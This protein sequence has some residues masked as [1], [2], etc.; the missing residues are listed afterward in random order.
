MIVAFGRFARF[1]GPRSQC[2]HDAGQHNPGAR[3]LHIPDLGK[4]AGMATV[5]HFDDYPRYGGSNLWT[6]QL[7]SEVRTR[8]RAELPSRYA[9][10]S[11][12]SVY[13]FI[14][15]MAFR[16]VPA[17]GVVPRGTSSSLTSSRLQVV[18][19]DL[20]RT[21]ERRVQVRQSV[22]AVIALAMFGVPAAAEPPSAAAVTAADISAAIGR[23]SPRFTDDE[24][25]RVLEAGP[26]RLGAFVVGRPKKT[27]PARIGADG[28]VE[29]TE[30]L[31]LDEISAVLQ[32]LSG[33][34]EFVV[35]GRLVHSARMTSDDPDA[36]VI[37]PGSRGKAIIGGLRRRNRAGR[38]RDHPG[39][40]GSR[41]C[42]HR[43][44]CDLP[45]DPRRLGPLPTPEVSVPIRLTSS[46]VEVVASSFEV[47]GPLPALHR[48]TS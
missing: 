22:T 41:L 8:I 16:V 9:H 38:H 20:F 2:S 17:G 6:P 29:V 25:L 30:G 45:R 26:N 11:I 43:D 14:S 15:A 24:P 18:A 3:C 47:V 36:S 27:G 28:A 37:G 32:M 13:R 48:S 23:L 35:G 1:P 33:T 21:L 39:W 40:R 44:S 46:Q 10:L 7:Q 31:R 12:R 4:P 5:V 34:G 42:R 19:C